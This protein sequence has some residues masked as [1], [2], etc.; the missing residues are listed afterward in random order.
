MRFTRENLAEIVAKSSTFDE[1]L[2]NGYLVPHPDLDQGEI[3]RRLDRWCEVAA[4]G[5]REQF[6]KLLALRAL[7]L[8][9][10]RSGL[11]RVRLPDG[12]SLPNWT[13]LLQ[14]GLKEA[15]MQRAEPFRFLDPT[16]PWPFEKLVAPFVH[17]AGQSLRLRA[18][19]VLC[20]LTDKAH[21]SL[22]RTLLHWLGNVCS[23]ALL[24][25]FSIFRLKRQ[26]PF[27]GRLAEYL[28]DS[29]SEIYRDFCGQMLGGGLVPFLQEYSGLARAVATL[30]KNWVDS[31]AEFLSRLE[32]DR[33]S[34]AKTFQQGRD[35]GEVEE[36]S[37]GL[38]DPH[39]KGRSVFALTFSSGSKLIYKPKSLE[40]EDSYTRLVE[41][42]NGH[43]LSL[44][45]K[46]LHVL[47]RSGYGWAEFV[48]HCAPQSE[49][50]RARFYRRSGMLLC[51]FYVL[52]T[53]DVHAENLIAAG[54]Y[55]VVVDAETLITPSLDENKT[56]D[57]LASA[58]TVAA[59]NMNTSV[60]HVGMLPWLRSLGNGHFQ[61]LSA[62]GGV[63]GE[64]FFA[65]A[66]QG[67]ETDNLARQVVTGK[68]LRNQN[69]PF[70]ADE[71]AEPA[72]YVEEV[73]GGFQEMYNLLLIRRD[74]LLRPGSP[75]DELARSPM[76]LIFRDTSTYFSLLKNSVDAA[77]LRDGAERSIHL[78]LLSRV[79]L[80]SDANARFAPFLKAEK[81]ALADLDIPFFTA[82][83]QSRALNISPDAV[84]EN[85]FTRAGFEDVR[86]RLLKLGNENLRE[87]ISIIRGSFW[88]KAASQRLPIST[89]EVEY[90][91]LADQSEPT[92][93][94]LLEQASV[95]V[96]LLQQSAIQGSDGSFTWLSLI[97]QA[98]TH[99]YRFGPLGP[100]L[101]DG[102]TGIALFLAAL[103][104]VSPGAGSRQMAIGALGP[105]RR[106]VSA[107]EKLFQTKSK[108]SLQ[109]LTV[110]LTGFGSLVYGLTRVGQ[111]LGEE[112][113]IEIACAAASLIS[114]DFFVSEPNMDI[115][116][117][118]AGAI[119]GLL[120]LY[121]IR[122]SALL[123]DNAIA[124]GDKILECRDSSA[125]GS[126]SA[127]LKGEAKGFAHGPVGLAHALLRLHRAT[128]DRRFLHASQEFL[129]AT[130]FQ[131][132]TD[133]PDLSWRTGAA[134][135]GL[136]LL[137]TP[138]VLKNNQIFSSLERALQQC[139]STS[140][141]G[142]D[143][144]CSGIAGRLDFLVEASQRAGYGPQVLA[145]ARKQAG[146]CINRAKR[147][148]G[149]YLHPHLPAGAFLPSFYEGL[150]GIGYQFLRL[151]FPEKLP[152]VLLWN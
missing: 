59:R 97:A 55:P 136:G 124:F 102:L 96:L 19:T 68:A 56:G 92:E 11:G 43:D 1:R 117:G 51:L 131:D 18:S 47:S 129:R 143:Q 64:Q 57:A 25:E 26:A 115:F 46:G 82:S 133:P 15:A 110:G 21:S 93:N 52:G 80:A 70:A 137:D 79:L 116:N 87:Q 84:V 111:L 144:V 89:P 32:T 151:A 81:E 91:A 39:H 42:I 78:E 66:W 103:E 140:L 148:S 95:I 20:A 40:T 125:A 44:Q 62:L 8:D 35:L 134:G 67:L 85:C 100:N 22:E 135:V 48:E 142:P 139:L 6:Q 5:D 130:C 126:R 28:A 23:S 147:N 10:I 63:G 138:G 17:A 29:S 3:N 71:T 114:P 2:A 24:L 27:G 101:F 14:D 132:E 83:P 112:T 33:V 113:P 120:S 45:L 150:A 69:V 75:L 12:V 90:T 16:E 65:M 88:A 31:T 37:A 106:T 146:W 73:A 127:S 4:K 30:M 49:A 145:A 7:D 34:L 104:R 54:E 105:I 74:A 128:N 77:L 119:L 38:S 60:L 152:S 141:S 61:D 99:N 107:Y 9:S 36:L 13:D 123:L 41:W 149:F 118:R 108:S 76:R 53:T 109:N 121:E 94:D 98:N 72:R 50:E 122:P 86:E 58:E